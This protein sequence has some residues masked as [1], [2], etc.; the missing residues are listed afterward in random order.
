MMTTAKAKA[1]MFE[2][3]IDKPNGSINRNQS[4]DIAIQITTEMNNR[5]NQLVSIGKKPGFFC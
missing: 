5:S 1:M 3:Q 2:I 4:S